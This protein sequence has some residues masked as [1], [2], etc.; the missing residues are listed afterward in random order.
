[1]IAEHPRPTREEAQKIARQLIGRAAGPPAFQ[2]LAD[3]E[4]S[5][6]GRGKTQNEAEVLLLIK[7]PHG[8]CSMLFIRPDQNKSIPIPCRKS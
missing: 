1:V 7:T 6:L 2:L 4:F 5:M 3:R 8:R